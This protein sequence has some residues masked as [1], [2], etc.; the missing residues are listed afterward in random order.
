MVWPSRRC[1][2]PANNRAAVSATPPGANDTMKVMGRLGYSSA[3]ADVRAHSARASSRTP[4][5]NLRPRKDIGAPLLLPIVRRTVSPIR[6]VDARSR[7]PR[8]GRFTD[9]HLSER[10]KCFTLPSVFVSLVAKQN[11]GVH[12]HFAASGGCRW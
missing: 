7:E 2:L 10:E 9:P 3:S 11:E 1:R 5:T 4:V 6:S 12:V 8:A